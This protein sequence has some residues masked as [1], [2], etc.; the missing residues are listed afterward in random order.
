MSNRKPGLFLIGAMKSGTTYL[1]KLLDSHPKIF[2]CEPDEPSYFV[3]PS[4]L[5]AIWT[6]MWERG[7]WRSEQRYL[8][9]FESAGD[10]I[11]LGEASTNYAKHPLVT[12]VAERIQAF[13]PDARFIYILRDPVERTLSHYWHMARYHAEQRPIVEAFRQDEQFVAVS[14]YAM[15]AMSF[16]ERFGRDR[17]AILTYENLVHDPA[18]VIRGLYEWLGVGTDG[19]DMSGFT[20]AEHV[21]P[22]LIRTSSWGGLPRRLWQSPSLREFLRPIPQP[23]QATLR[24]LTTREVRRR[25]V[26]VSDAIDFLRPIQR[27]QTE[28]L[29]QLLGRE[30]PEW[31]TLNGQSAWPRRTQEEADVTAH[32]QKA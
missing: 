9:L 29:V 31:T 8:E 24:R 4:Q 11:I 30:F 21:T 27:R 3:D 23:I 5:R 7:I 20:V 2:M 14:H 15:Q 16:L 32:S 25:S 19:V 10:A 26:D 17:V 28:E 1:R 12:G 13:N 18:G 22:D 6:D